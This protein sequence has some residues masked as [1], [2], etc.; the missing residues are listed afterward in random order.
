MEKSVR[1]AIGAKLQTAQKLNRPYT[2]SDN[3]VMNKQLN[4]L[5][6]TLPDVTPWTQYVGIG[7]GGLSARF[8]GEKRRIE[9]T[10]IPHDPRHTGFYEQIP[11][12]IRPVDEDLTTAERVNYRLRKLMDVGGVRYAAYYARKIDT[13]GMEVRLEYRVIQDGNVTS[14]PWEPSVDDQHPTPITVN[15]GQVLTTG[16]DYVASSAKSTLRFSAWDIAELI[17]VGRVLFDSEDAIV[18]S[19]IGLMSGIDFETRGDFNGVSLPITEA[20]GVQ[21]NDFV[22]TLIPTAYNQ[23]GAAVNLDIGS[24]EP[25]LALKS[26]TNGVT[27]P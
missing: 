27:G 19:E 14:T 12:V 23:A 11:F 6:D 9:L 1:T 5:P 3:S 18:V 20:I 13:T 26:S 2:F 4:I 7:I 16:D 21:I 17:N 24:T 10:P 8:I 25:L 22:S 15:P